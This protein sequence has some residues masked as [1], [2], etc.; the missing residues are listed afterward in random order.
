MI[1]CPYCNEY[2]NIAP[3]F[4]DYCSM[5]SGQII[6]QHCAKKFKYIYFTYGRAF[7]METPYQEYWDFK[8]NIYKIDDFAERL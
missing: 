5:A 1:Q 6:C 2:T 8:D 4:V 7:T 3:I